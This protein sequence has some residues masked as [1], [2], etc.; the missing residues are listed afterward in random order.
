MISPKFGPT[1]VSIGNPD[2]V[3]LEEKGR[4]WERLMVDV[5]LQVDTS[6]TDL[7]VPGARPPSS[8]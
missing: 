3:C 7:R 5:L 4:G 8:G 6:V 1:L 2:F